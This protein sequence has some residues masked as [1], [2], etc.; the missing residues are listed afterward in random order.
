MSAHLKFVFLAICPSGEMANQ[1]HYLKFYSQIFLLH[2]FLEPP[3][4]GGP[5]VTFYIS[6]VPTCVS[7]YKLD[8]NLGTFGAIVVIWRRDDNAAKIDGIESVSQLLMQFSCAYRSR[9]NSV[10]YI[11][12]L[13]GVG[14]MLIMFMPICKVGDL[15][16]L[17]WWW[18]AKLT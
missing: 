17:Y 18:T 3:K 13:L 11:L 16:T 7:I 8:L 5:A 10:S 15:M 1:M 4:C 12:L 6:V 14:M 2:C 9:L